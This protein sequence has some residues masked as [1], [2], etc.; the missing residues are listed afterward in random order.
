MK[1]LLADDEALVRSV[2]GRLLEY[3]GHD[4]VQVDSGEAALSS[5]RGGDG[6][7]LAILDEQMPGMRGSEVLSELR[8]ESS[9]LPVLLSSGDAG[10]VTED[11]RV[12][13]LGKPF[14]LEA[15]EEAIAKL[16]SP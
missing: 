10:I 1:V 3:L 16:C 9:D 15:L 8:S 4:V 11:P 5:L 12:M 13:I 2:V 14:R 7:G 6:F